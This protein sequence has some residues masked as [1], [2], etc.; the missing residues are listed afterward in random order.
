MGA[1]W[2][3]PS[4]TSLT[5]HSVC[6]L[7]ELKTAEIRYDFSSGSTAVSW[8]KLGVLARAWEDQARQ[9]RSYYILYV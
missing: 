8:F 3:L 1:S 9:E 4:V 7:F 2:G 5:G 6:K